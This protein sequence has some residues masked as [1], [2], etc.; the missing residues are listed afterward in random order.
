MSL[1]HSPKIVTDGLVLY[2]DMGNTKKSWKGAPTTNLQDPN[3]N[4]WTK[5]AIV[6]VL[7]E[8][9]PTNDLVYSITDNNATSYLNIYKHLTVPNNS[10]TYT[11][12]IYIKK[13]YGATSARLGFNTGFSGGTIP[14]AY[15]QRFNSDT[16]VG[17]SGTT[18]DLDYCWRWQFQL[19]N[20]NT[21]NTALSCAFY[22]AT[23]FYNGSDN[24]AAIGTAI[25]SGIQIEQSSFA[26]PFVNGTR[27]NTQSLLDLTN[28]NVITATNL[29]YN[30]DESFSFDGV[31]DYINCGNS[32]LLHFK[33][34][35]TLSVWFKLNNLSFTWSPLISKMNSNGNV[36]SRTYA[37]FIYSTGQIYLC[38][39]DATGQE[40][41]VSSPIITN[42][43][44]NWV[45]VIDRKQGIMTQYINGIKNTEAVVRL[46]NTISNSDPVFINQGGSGYSNFSGN[47]SIV[48]IYNRCLSAAEIKQNFNATRGRY[49]I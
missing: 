13:T 42:V 26:T 6:T 30:S 8:I 29:T 39:A 9:F 49:G 25:I 35:A 12:S 32:T 11:I 34:T 48:Q 3:I 40:A 22:P 14:L 19:T 24:S 47:V 27:T 5:S 31:D 43:W 37:V 44:I 2:Y 38:S 1:H 46:T 33:R 41:S 18:Q 10:N 17:T 45:G 21:G 23:G 4:N 15:N 7:N 20:N 16:G 36:P 28:N